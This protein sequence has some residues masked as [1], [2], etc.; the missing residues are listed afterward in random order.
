CNNCDHYETKEIAPKGH[1]FGEWYESKAP[2]YHE[3]GEEQRKCSSC[4]E[5]ESRALAALDYLLGDV[6]GDEKINVLDANLVRRYAAELDELDE[7]QLA[8]ADVNGDGKVN[9][10]DANLIRRFAAKLI[11]VFPVEE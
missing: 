10:L 4:G 6:N 1:S 9:V 7:K 11:T 8:A 5:T 2:T 3:E